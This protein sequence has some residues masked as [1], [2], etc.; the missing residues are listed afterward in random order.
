MFFY[1]FKSLIHILTHIYSCLMVEIGEFL[2]NLQ[3]VAML[4][5]I[6]KSPTFKKKFATF[7]TKDIYKYDKVQRAFD[8]FGAPKCL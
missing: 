1:S 5:F 4:I 7:V 2:L 3:D 6:F 8:S